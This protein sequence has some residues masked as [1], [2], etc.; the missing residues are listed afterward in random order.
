MRSKPKNV[1]NLDI[2]TDQKNAGRD[3]L[4]VKVREI[5]ETWKGRGWGFRF[6][7]R[8]VETT[9]LMDQETDNEGK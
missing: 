5:V 7:R 2:S 4:P 3:T 8:R 6:E 9:K 1:Q